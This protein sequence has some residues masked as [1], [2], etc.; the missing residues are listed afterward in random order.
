MK[1]PRMV[2]ATPAEQGCA[3]LLVIAAQQ[4]KG[5]LGQ[6]TDVVTAAWPEACAVPVAVVN[7]NPTNLVTMMRTMA[8]AART[9]PRP[10]CCDRCGASYDLLGQAELLL[11]MSKG[12]G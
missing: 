8:H 6:A 11:T 1:T 2:G 12:R 4:L 7:S 5:V 3:D 9:R 10:T